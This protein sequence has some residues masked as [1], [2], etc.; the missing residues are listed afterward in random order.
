[1]T[2]QS[3]RVSSRR[4]TSVQNHTVVTL[5][6]RSPWISLLFISGGFIAAALLITIPSMKP[7]IVD[8]T[9]ARM[10]EIGLRIY[11]AECASCH[12]T[13]L[14]GQPSWQVR[15]ANGKLPAP[16]HDPSGHTWHHSDKVLFDI[17]KKG[18]AA[19][20]D[21]YRTDMPA[22]GGRLSDEQIAAVL[23]FIKST[24]PAEILQRQPKVRN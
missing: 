1:M 17:T 2:G 11:S 9:N 18:P 19:Y 15:L 24:W 20:P 12:G 10:V 23:A 16:P 13:K 4:R 7:P 6:K 3:K 21:G 22:F 5:F 14:E 8:H